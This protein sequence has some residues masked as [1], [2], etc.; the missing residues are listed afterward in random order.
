MALS[1]EYH[2]CDS[3]Y[4]LRKPLHPLPQTL[5]LTWLFDLFCRG[6][7]NS[8]SHWIVGHFLVPT[9]A[10]LWICREAT[11]NEDC[12]RGLFVYHCQIYE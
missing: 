3:N 11:L 6:P 7:S 1:F 12:D 4:N 8:V 5:D 10:Y 9:V 2:D